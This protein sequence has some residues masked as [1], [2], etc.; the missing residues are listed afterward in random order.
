VSIQLPDVTIEQVDEISEYLNVAM[1]E[2][3]E[4]MVRLF[5]KKRMVKVMR[6]LAQRSNKS[7]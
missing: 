3:M 2:A 1:D 7:R 6:N 4:A 5:L